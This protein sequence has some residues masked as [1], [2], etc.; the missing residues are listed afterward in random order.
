M[1]AS[2][3]LMKIVPDSRIRPGSYDF[4]KTVG[5]YTVF[6]DEF[7]RPKHCRSRRRER[8]RH[9]W[10]KHA[11]E[12]GF[13][14]T[15]PVTYVSK[16]YRQG[17]GELF[18]KDFFRKGYSMFYAFNLE[19]AKKILGRYVKSDAVSS[20]VIELWEDGDILAICW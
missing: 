10:K 13:D 19:D 18:T 1:S 9:A 6:P 8:Y 17:W 2:I 5:I 14:I 12:I 4:E 16:F 7:W 3:E 20:N 15:Q 11:K